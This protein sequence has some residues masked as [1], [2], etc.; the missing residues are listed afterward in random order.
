L[1]R[2][3]GL[4]Q[5]GGHNSRGN[6]P[7]PLAHELICRASAFTS[8]PP[9]PPPPPALSFST[10]LLLLQLGCCCPCDICSQQLQSRSRFPVHDERPFY[11]ALTTIRMLLLLLRRQAPERVNKS[12]HTSPLHARAADV[13][14][15]F[16][17]SFDRTLR[18]HVCEPRVEI[19]RRRVSGACSMRERSGGGG[20]GGGGGGGGGARVHLFRSLTAYAFRAQQ[21]IN[22]LQR[23]VRI[24][25][26]A[27]CC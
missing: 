1:H 4:L 10:L 19:L 15:A 27:G 8:S 25:R 3:E 20:D 17:T 24:F 26:N 7:F 18:L 14:H 5:R 21:R 16:F 12:F 22:A 9:I 6:G 2:L 13:D 23:R 11:F